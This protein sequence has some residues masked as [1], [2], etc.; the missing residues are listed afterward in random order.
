MIF[1]NKVVPKDWEKAVSD[2]SHPNL[3]HSRDM[4]PWQLPP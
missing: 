2:S 4:L 1:E 3:N